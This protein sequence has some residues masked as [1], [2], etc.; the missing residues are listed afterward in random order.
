MARSR[1]CRPGDTLGYDP[2]L[3]TVDGAERLAQGL[4]QRR[5][6]AGAG[7]AQSGRRDLD[8]P[9][10]AAA[11]RGRAARSALRRRDRRPR[12][13]R[14]SAP[15]SASCAPTRWWSPIRTRSPG[16]STSAAPTSRTRRCRSPSPSCPQEGRPTLYIDGRKLSNAVRHKLEELAE[17]REPGGVRRDLAGARRARSDRAARSGDRRRR[18]VAHRSRDAGGKVT[19]GADPIALM[20]AV[21]NA[22]EIEGARAAHRAR[23]RGGGALPRLVRPRSAER[24]AH[25]DRRGRGAGKLPPRHRRCSRTCRSR[26]SPAPA[27]TAPSCITA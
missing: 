2:W 4:R 6:D 17:V 22:V 23:R 27:R 24:Q 16:P 14:A 19:R 18:A 10:A 26:P 25:R 21:K 20:K 13:S 1:T 5:R 3:H 12:S 15:R 7:R 11:R 9:P 8:R